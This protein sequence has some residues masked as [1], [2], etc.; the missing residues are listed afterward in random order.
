[1]LSIRTPL[2]AS[3]WRIR[4]KVGDTITSLDDPL[5]IL[6][7]MKTEIPI[8]AE[9]IHLGQTIKAFG[10]AVKEGALVKP[11]DVLITV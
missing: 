1:V 7:A 10:R 9:Q 4:C 5:M 6:E 11:G 2:F 8:K 3:I